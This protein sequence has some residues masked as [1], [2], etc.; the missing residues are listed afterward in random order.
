MPQKVPA[1][2]EDVTALMGGA[3]G[4]PGVGEDVTALMGATEP[5]EPE[6]PP[7]REG[8]LKRYGQSFA[9][10]VLP[11]TTPSD[12][13]EGP[14]YAAQHPVD[15]MGLILGGIWDATKGVAGKAADAAGRVVS[16]PTIGGK[17]GAASE[18]LGYGAATLMP[19][20]GPAAAAAGE[21]GARGD[22]A[23]MLGAT[24]GI[25]T[26]FAAAKAGRA[27]AGLRGRAAARLNESAVKGVEK[28]INP[29]R[30][31][32]KV[33][34]ARI[35]PEMLER[36]ISASSLPKLEALAAEKSAI[37][38]EKVGEA[39]APY[40]Q[41]TTPTAFILDKL[42]KAKA[43][44]VGTA[45]DGASVVNDPARVK[46]L[47]KLQDTVAE[48][49]DA[50][51]VESMV[52]LRRNLDRIVEEGK[53]FTT[54]KVKNRAWAARE[55]RTAIRQELEQTVPNINKL[56]AEYSF[57]QTLEDVTAASNERKVGQNGTLLTTIAGAGGAVA[58]EMMAP[59]AGMA[60]SLKRLLD[61]PGYRLWSSV[62]KARLADAL[63]AGD[64][65]A[66]KGLIAAGLDAA[67]TTSRA[68]GRV[69]S[70]RTPQA[71]SDEKPPTGRVAR[72]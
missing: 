16:E 27:T 71:A 32:T 5:A 9:R 35:A 34:T 23:G 44:Y 37:A 13:I 68:S 20:V 62:Q 25:M 14:M 29:T 52:K 17:L 15:S 69:V 1:I 6:Q 18:T 55:A 57:W 3:S 56:N 58:G 40:A 60:A 53:G 54:A 41:E 42:E 33:Q 61:S 49:G 36:R 21:Q 2:G 48:Y 24:T 67:G 64:A 11:S 4:V 47:Q 43:D 65:A 45:Q 70:G 10:N 28:A 22:V 50:I 46:S 8:A 26:P 59:G 63:A 72:R 12:Y 7:V 30:K 51:S 39:L 31:D 19:V 38:G 66:A